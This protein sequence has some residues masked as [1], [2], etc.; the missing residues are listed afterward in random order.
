VNQSKAAHKAER[1]NLGILDRSVGSAALREK[2]TPG[3]SIGCKRVLLSDDYYPALQQPHVELVT[4]KILRIEDHAIITESD[5]HPA[6]ILVFATGFR[7]TEFLAPMTIIGRCGRSL[8]EQWNG[9]AEAYLGIT[10]AHFPNFFMLY[11]P[12]TNLG[13]SS[14]I[15]MI[16]CQVNYVMKCL[17]AVRRL[18]RSTI[19]VKEDVM[20][21][22]IRKLSGELERM[23]WAASCSNWYKLASGRVLNN[24]SGTT[25]WYWW[26]TRKPKLA[27]YRLN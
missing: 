7:A 3:Y 24:W 1:N 14:I 17:K 26:R 8:H 23:A 18:G 4:D 2:L 20:R 16:E 5:R 19:E 6:D 21:D 10:V 15:F 9:A 27:E 12:N 22:F 25:S 13:H 11:G